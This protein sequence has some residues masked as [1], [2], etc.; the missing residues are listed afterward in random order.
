[1]QIRACKCVYG[2][3]ECMRRDRRRERERTGSKSRQRELERARFARKLAS[4]LAPLLVSPRRTLPPVPA[5][6]SSTRTCTQLD[7]PPPAELTSL[8]PVPPRLVCA[9]LCPRPRPRRRRP[10]SIRPHPPSLALPNLCL[11]EKTGLYAKGR[12]T[13]QQRGKRNVRTNTNLVQIEG[14]ADA[15]EAQFYLGKVSLDSACCELRTCRSR[16]NA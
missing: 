8:C 12:V 3:Y 14:V 10:P 5:T 13:G 2:G 6:M 4:V 15:K 11:P 7:Y 1:M 9:L 16:G